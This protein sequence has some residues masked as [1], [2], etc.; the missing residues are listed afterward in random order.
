MNDEDLQEA[1]IR[2]KK[3]FEGHQREKEA[4]YCIRDGF[5]PLIESCAD[6]V[7]VALYVDDILDEP[8][9]VGIGDEENRLRITI[10]TNGTV[11]YGWINETWGKIFRDALMTVNSLAKKMV[12]LFRSIAEMSGAIGNEERLPITN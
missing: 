3:K 1:F 10:K 9:I 12:S 7:R 11:T 4:F 8:I 5:T 6:N 2:V